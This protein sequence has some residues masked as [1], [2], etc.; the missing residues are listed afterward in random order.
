MAETSGG[1]TSADVAVKV[2]VDGRAR[3]CVHV[4]DGQG[5]SGASITVG[6]RRLRLASNLDQPATGPP[7][8]VR[9]Y[10]TSVV[11]PE[12]VAVATA[13][14][15]WGQRHPQVATLQELR[16]GPG[17]TAHDARRV[18]EIALP[19]LHARGVRRIDVRVRTGS[20][21]ADVFDDANWFGAPI[22]GDLVLSRALP[23][24]WRSRDH[25]A[26]RPWPAGN[27]ALRSLA[28]LSRRVAAIR[29]V[30]IPGIVLTLIEDRYQLLRRRR[31]SAP[32]ASL[33]DLGALPEGTMPHVE[34]RYRTIRRALDLVPPAM[35]QTV[36]LDVG[37]GSGRVLELAESRGFRTVAGIE[38]DPDLAERSRAL[39]STGARVAVGDALVEPLDP[40]V[41]VVFMNNPFDVDAIGRFADLVRR[42]LDHSPRP[43]LVLYLNPQTFDP[44]LAIGLR[45]CHVDPLFTI[46]AH[47]PGPRP[48]T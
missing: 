45:L 11:W 25:T 12:D 35:R 13:R 43:L 37:S 2:E 23:P 29:P 21:E 24:P 39:L 38:H 41:G 46:L 18:V 42:S 36:L 4:P 7:S 40:A 19:A 47:H 48:S 1:A 28:R 15:R 16:L 26:R 33:A 32:H 8:A 17:A 34:S 31:R 44:F 5:G 10:P 20:P 6:R 9:R 27:E 14:V 30:L 3:I 22:A